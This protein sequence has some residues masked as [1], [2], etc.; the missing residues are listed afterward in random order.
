M[1][2]QGLRNYTNLKSEL[3]K[4]A[5]PDPLDQ[6]R[7]IAAQCYQRDHCQMLWTGACRS[8]KSA[9]FDVLRSMT[10]WLGSKPLME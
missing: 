2:F 4:P 5:E 8:A 9:I 6:Y 1:T 3:F 10:S 7:A